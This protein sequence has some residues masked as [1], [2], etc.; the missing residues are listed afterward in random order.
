MRRFTSPLLLAVT[1]TV[2]LA[3]ST[4]VPSPAMAEAAPL[5]DTHVQVKIDFIHFTDAVVEN[6]DTEDDFYLGVEGY[7]RISPNIYLGGEIGVTNPDGR[8]GGLGGVATELTYIPIEINAKYAGEAAPNII[9]DFGVGFSFNYVDEEHI[10]TPTS[11]EEDWV[12][13]GQFFGGLSYTS[14]DYFLGFGFKYQFTDDFKDRADNGSEFN[15]TNW[16]LGGR[17]GFYF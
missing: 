12:L 8:R 10:A 16:R 7:R 9:L 4:L 3:L 1:A 2:T 13:G 11:N 5:G 6:S 14:G 17:A 15:F